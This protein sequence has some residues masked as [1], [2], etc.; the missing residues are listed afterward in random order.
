MPDFYEFFAGGGM[1]RAGLGDG[2][3][4]LFANDFSPM[5]A[6]AYREN[7]GGE[8]FVEGDVRALAPADLPG[9]ADMVWAS[10][11]CQDLSLAGDGGGLGRPEDV[12]TRSGAFWPWLSLMRKLAVDGRK[13][14]VIVFENVV[15]ALSSNQGRDF[16]TVSRAFADSGYRFGA[17]AIDA[18]HFLPQ[19]RPR[20]FIVGID[21]DATIPA[22]VHKAEPRAPWHSEAVRNAFHRLPASLREDWVW[23]TLP[24]PLAHRPDLSS[25][26][27]DRPTGV[28]WHSAAATQKLVAAMSPANI[29][30]LRQ[31]QALGR[32]IVGTVYKRTRPDAGGGKVWRAEVRF[33]QIA[34]CLRTPSGGSSRQT[35]MVVDGESVRTRLMSTRE[36]ARL[37]GLPDR[38]KLPDNY[39]DAY[40]VCGD[41]VAVPVVGFL[42]RYLLEPLV[43]AGHTNARRRKAG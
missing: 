5:K 1:A 30:K 17:L 35:V 26:I 2:W 24:P 7:W 22:A 6:A 34:G 38:Y 36:A 33:D 41:G 28:P 10:T 37:M 23:W 31:A 40:H 27:E 15:G 42:R 16:E 19:S 18:K 20:L 8:H 14:R 32:R 39:N 9:V 11:P 43:R 25:L 21:R 3:N 12:P 13:P 4:C 29:A